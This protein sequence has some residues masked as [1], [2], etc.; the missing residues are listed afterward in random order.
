MLLNGGQT[1]DLRIAYPN[2]PEKKHT[3]MDPEKSIPIWIAEKYLLTEMVTTFQLQSSK[4]IC[5]SIFRP[6]C[7][8]ID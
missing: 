1:H 6:N 2:H 4:I 5:Q 8:E 7:V 3:N